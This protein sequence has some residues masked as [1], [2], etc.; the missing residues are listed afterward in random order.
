MKLLCNWIKLSFFL[1]NFL[2][3]CYTKFTSNEKTVGA[4]EIVL[5]E[6]NWKS[7]SERVD[8]WVDSDFLSAIAMFMESASDVKIHTQAFARGL[9]VASSRSSKRSR[10]QSAQ[11][12]KVI[13]RLFTVRSLQFSFSFFLA[14]RTQRQMLQLWQDF[15]HRLE[16][17]FIYGL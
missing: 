10:M 7:A 16:K 8:S 11:R 1:F 12:D 13:R 5:I 17:S 4:L 6:L 15:T 3:L 2:S 9:H 14:H